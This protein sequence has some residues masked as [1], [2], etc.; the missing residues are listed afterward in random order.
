MVLGYHRHNVERQIV[1]QMEGHYF[2]VNPNTALFGGVNPMN[3]T[4]E[5]NGVN[6]NTRAVVPTKGMGW[7]DGGGCSRALG[8]VS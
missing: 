7:A 2:Y 5:S 6:T 1:L 3:P 8:I 4:K